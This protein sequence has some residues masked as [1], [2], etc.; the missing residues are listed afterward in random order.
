MVKITDAFQHFLEPHTF[1]HFNWRY[2][3]TCGRNADYCMKAHY[4]LWQIA[5]LKNHHKK[6]MEF[7][8]NRD[9]AMRIKTGKRFGRFGGC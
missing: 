1:K 5:P 3:Y 6:L 7:L 2:M 4:K 9:D 8:I